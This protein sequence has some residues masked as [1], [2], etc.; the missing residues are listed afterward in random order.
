MAPDDSFEISGG[1]PPPAVLVVND[2]LSQ[3]VAIRAMLSSLDVVVAEADSGR[4]ALRAVL[5]RRFAVILMD[6]RMP[7]MDGYETA[8][9]IRQRSESSRTPIIFLTAFGSED[10]RASLVAYESGAVDFIVTPVVPEV[11]RAKVAAFVDLFLRADELERS[12]DSITMLNAALRDSQAST[13]AVLDSVADGIVTM[14]DGGLIEAFNPSARLLFGY[15]EEDVIG[16]PLTLMIAPARRAEFPDLASAAP[17]SLLAPGTR[18]RPIETLGCRRDGSTF[19]MDVEHRLISLGGRSLTLAFVRDV[20]E[21]QAYTES[22]E[23]QALQD[24]LTGLANRTLFCEHGL[25]ALAAGKRNN[26]PRAVVVMDLDGFKQVNDTLDHDQGDLMLK[27]VAKRL[28]AVLREADVV[29]RLGGDEFAILPGGATD[30]TA[31]AELAWKIQQACKPGFVITD[32]VVYISASVG[33][34]MFPEHGTTPAALLR[35][36]GAAKHLAKRSGTGHAVFDAAQETDVARQ[37]ALLVDLRQCAARG[38]LVLHYQ[39]K[40]DLAT[41]EISGVEAL[42]RWQHPKLG[43]LAPDSFMPEVERTALIEPVTRWVLNEA[44]RQQST[45]REDGFDLTVAVNISAHSLRPNSNLPE[46]VAELTQTWGTVPKRLTLELTEG[47]LIEAPAPGILE[48]LDKLGVRISIDD[49]GTGHSSLSYLQ[50]LPV[51]EVKID[52]SFITNLKA[53][54]DVAIIV[55]SMI[56][57]AHSLGL[58]VVAE[59]VENQA[60]MDLL[61]EDGCDSAQGFLLGRPSEADALTRWL[62]EWPHRPRV[63]LGQ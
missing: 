5:G 37:L 6:V 13:Q 23:R 55:R 30:L 14:G 9:L 59:G 10:D 52:T 54:D 63:A 18:Q 45:W 44:L 35:R 11:L 34:A 56:D 2:R 46:V 26:E 43:L 19:A 16:Q 58:S 49:F 8:E 28:V 3:R 7:N 31:A 38:E 62:T 50:P 4:A 51:D 12:L 22:L 29:A 47:A 20:S 40:I 25:K 32:Q 60:A 1:Q 53:D 21:R 48:R 61:I 27:Q 39:P 17:G 15:R 41:R 57:L 24:D 36:A 42:V 33:I